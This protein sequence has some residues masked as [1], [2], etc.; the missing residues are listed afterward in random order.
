MLNRWQS[1]IGIFLL[2]QKKWNF[3]FERSSISGPQMAHFAFG[4]GQKSK[5]DHDLL[6]PFS[7]FVNGDGNRRFR[8]MFCKKLDISVLTEWTSFLQSLQEE[9][10]LNHPYDQEPQIST[11]SIKWLN[12]KRKKCN[13][14]NKIWHL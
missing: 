12:Y 7:N 4:S 10:N 3:S 13:M 9:S 11:S 5:A 14:L 1:N 8:K 6:A 2:L